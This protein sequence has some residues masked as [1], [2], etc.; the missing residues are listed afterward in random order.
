MQQT[1]RPK[2]INELRDRLGDA[3]AKAESDPKTLAQA[4][5][6]A[7]I[8]GKIL[9]SIKIQYEYSICRREE[10]YIGFMGSPSKKMLSS[11]NK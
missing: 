6:L 10:P 4:E 11:D 2:D 7:N 1:Q 8:A 3:F 9:A 5:A